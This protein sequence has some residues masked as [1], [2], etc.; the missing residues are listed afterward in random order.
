MAVSPMEFGMAFRFGF[1]VWG[2]GL[3][4][5]AV[6]VLKG[7]PRVLTRFQALACRA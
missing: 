5:L 2:L 7:L 3:K 4:G 1:R 6:W